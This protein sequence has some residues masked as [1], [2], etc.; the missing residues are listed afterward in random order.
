MLLLT[1]SSF[2]RH[3]I[4]CHTRPRTRSVTRRLLQRCPS[5][6]AESNDGH[7][8]TTAERRSSGGQRY[9]FDSGLLPLLHTELHCV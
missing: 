8:G 6:L 7:D 2:I 5:G 3:G 9:K 4:G 1:S